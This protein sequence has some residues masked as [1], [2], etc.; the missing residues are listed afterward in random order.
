M[1]GG[2]LIIQNS[3]ESFGL[4]YIH[5]SS[6]LHLIFDTTVTRTGGWRA[7]A[8]H[9]HGLLPL[10][11]RQHGDWRC[12]ASRDERHAADC[13]LWATEELRA[14]AS[15]LPC[16]PVQD[17]RQSWDPVHDWYVPG[18]CSVDCRGRKSWTGLNGNT[19]TLVFTPNRGIEKLIWRDVFL[20]FLSP[21]RSLD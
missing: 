14:R 1:F 20:H 3:R 17:F 11:W 13:A 10:G 19:I 12:A 4:C 21:S 16:S 9:V 2:L 7:G 5:A 6:P 15:P 18:T 8:R